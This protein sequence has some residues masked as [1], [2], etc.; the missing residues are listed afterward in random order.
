LDDGVGEIVGEAE[1]AAQEALP[2]SEAE[3]ADFFEN[4]AR[5]VFALDF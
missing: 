2:I 3:K 1:V 5:Q 4:I